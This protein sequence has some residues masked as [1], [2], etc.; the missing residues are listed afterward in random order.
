MEHLHIFL[1][2]SVLLSFCNSNESKQLYSYFRGFSASCCAITPLH[3]PLQRTTC[4][5][6]FLIISQFLLDGAEL[7][8]Y[9]KHND[10]FDRNQGFQ[11]RM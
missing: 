6:S 1:D 8:F 4:Q 11:S 3:S 10:V 7:Y 2:N 5:Q 9:T